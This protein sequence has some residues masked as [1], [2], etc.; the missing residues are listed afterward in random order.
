MHRLEQTLRDLERGT[1]IALAFYND[2]DAPDAGNRHDPLTDGWIR[3]EHPTAQRPIEHAWR[4]F[5][6]SLVVRTS[7]RLWTTAASDLGRAPGTL[8]HADFRLR[9]RTIDAATLWHDSMLD[10]LRPILMHLRT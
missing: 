7:V 8:W 1:F 6:T 4:N 10:S 5:D 3:G 2:M 9:G